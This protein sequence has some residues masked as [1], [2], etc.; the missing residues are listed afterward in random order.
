[1]NFLQDLA[2][3]TVQKLKQV[4]MMPRITPAGRLGIK[5]ASRYLKRVNYIGKAKSGIHNG[6]A[7]LASKIPM[8]M[9]YI[10]S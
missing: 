10:V 4:M 1:M 2:F 7:P 3:Q 6:H 8:I 5:M 9:P